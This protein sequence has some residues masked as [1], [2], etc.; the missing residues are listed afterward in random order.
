[1]NVEDLRADEQA[2]VT[3]DERQA[4]TEQVKL[5]VK[6]EQRLHRSQNALD[7]QLVRVELLS[8]FALRW[9]S[10]SSQTQ[11]LSDSVRLFKRL[12]SV[13]RAIAVQAE[14]PA[15]R[16][17]DLSAPAGKRPPSGVVSVPAD[18]IAEALG[19]V[20][21]PI[22]CPPPS[23]EARLRELLEQAKV[24]EATD[25]A[26][27]MVVVMPLCAGTVRD[28]IPDQSCPCGLNTRRHSPSYASRWPI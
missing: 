1:M 6:T 24:V 7:R 19:G 14:C 16:E 10:G 20:S 2:P 18:A 25:S 11:I 15:P 3:H 8:Q 21:T 9:D 17:V 12:F 4:L 22:V 23:L 13:E 28:S 26:K 5:L 27:A